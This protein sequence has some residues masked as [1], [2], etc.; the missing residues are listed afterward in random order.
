YSA[1][2][3]KPFLLI[4]DEINMAAAIGLVD[5]NEVLN[6]LL[7]VDPS[8]TV[9]LTGR[10]APKEFIRIAGYVTKIKPIK[11]PKNAAAKIGIDY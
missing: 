11:F 5:K 9:Y 3:K 6:L 1:A 8:V 2:K 7:H 4:L 10:Y